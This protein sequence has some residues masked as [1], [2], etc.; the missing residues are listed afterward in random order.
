[1]KVQVTTIGPNGIQDASF[2]IHAQGCQDIRQRKYHRAEKYDEVITSVED[3]VETSYSD[4]I[5]E[6]E[7]TTWEDYANEFKIFP[8]VGDLPYTQ[9]AADIDEILIPQ[10]EPVIESHTVEE[11]IEMIEHTEKRKINYP[12]GRNQ[13]AVVD[14]LG[15]FGEYFKGC[16]WVWYYHSS[17]IEVLDGL[18]SRGLVE[19]YT[20][21]EEGYPIWI[22]TEAGHEAFDAHD[23]KKEEKESEVA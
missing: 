18:E 4:I 8:C 22:L 12:L 20:H 17:T 3:L 9:A 10:S 16:D 2:H 23:P 6:N 11:V 19:K 13:L 1:M 7:G 15:N 21:R 5:A 14:A